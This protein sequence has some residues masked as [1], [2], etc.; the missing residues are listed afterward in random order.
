MINVGLTQACPNYH[1]GQLIS[2]TL[3]IQLNANKV[4]DKESHDTTEIYQ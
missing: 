2:V 1:G 4:L 3:S